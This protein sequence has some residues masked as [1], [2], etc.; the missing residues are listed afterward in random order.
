MLYSVTAL[1]EKSL[2][3]AGERFSR[4]SPLHLRQCRFHLGQPE[5]HL[6]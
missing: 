2:N 1:G 4:L 5:G 3:K 6:H